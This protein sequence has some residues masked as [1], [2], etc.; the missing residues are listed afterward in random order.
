M[1]DL[2][3]DINTRYGGREMREVFRDHVNQSGALG[4]A[5][6]TWVRYDEVSTLLTS[7]S[8]WAAQTGVLLADT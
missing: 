6:D 3:E 4:K 7:F 1:L 8:L 2:L 5:L